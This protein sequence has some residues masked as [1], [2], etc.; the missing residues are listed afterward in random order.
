[1]G[2]A[3]EKDQE[4]PF[5]ALVEEIRSK[6]PPAA[7]VES[8]HECFDGM[9]EDDKGRWVPCP[10]CKARRDEAM[11]RMRL[12]SS[13]IAERYLDVGW[14]DLEMLPPFPLVRS[15]AERIGDL[16]H[17][18]ESAVFT[19]PVGTGK[20]QA[21]LLL[22]RAAVRAGFEARVVNVGWLGVE[23]RST[24]NGGEGIT[25]NE[26]VRLMAQPDL[27]LLDDVGAGE[28]RN[29]ELERRLLY[30]A[31]EARNQNRRPTIITTNLGVGS[32]S[33]SRATLEQYLGGRIWDRLKPL[34][35][36]AFK[37]GKNF[38]EREISVW[39]N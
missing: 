21:G 12:Q 22:V 26:A 30:L 5:L 8:D 3:P 29:A 11:L 9:V 17:A 31:L 15:V 20:T 14:D 38:R 1:M 7:R 34:R 18:G 6:N 35:V 4:N 2:D 25:E 33:A 32:K 24:W 28:T 16:I 19:G 10:V 27:L 37:H 36:V 39:A 23:V 13:G